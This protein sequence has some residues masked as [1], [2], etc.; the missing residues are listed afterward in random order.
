MA[1]IATL[2]ATMLLAC[3]G[4]S[5]VLLGSTATTLSA[6]DAQASAAESAAESALT[7]AMSELA[8]RTDWSGILTGSGPD[9]CAEPGRF[10]DASLFPRAPW[11]GSLI[12]LHSLT[13]ALQAASDGD[14]PSGAAGPVWRLFDY[15]PISTLI[16]SEPRRHPF[17]VA[18]W[19]ADGGAGVVLLRAV[20]LGT[21]EGRASLEASAGRAEGTGAMVRLAVRTIRW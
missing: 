19:T 2:F 14:V 16:P 7:L 18:V 15:G 17:Y 13:A 8:E 11:D 4:T 5:L 21:A 6:R 10:V 9:V 1:L 3:L 20:A 12:D